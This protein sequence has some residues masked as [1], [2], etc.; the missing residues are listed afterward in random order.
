LGQ[1]AEALDSAGKAVELYESLR[2]L[3]DN[4]EL[5]MLWRETAS[6]AYELH[7]HDDVTRSAQESGLLDFARL[8][9]SRREADLLSSLDP[10]TLASVDFAATREAAASADV[11]RARLVHFATH[12]LMNTAHP[13][14]SGLVLSLVDEHGQPRD[15]FLRLHAIYDL[16][17]RADLVVL[18]ACQTAVG[19]EF[20]GE[21]MV[22]LTRGFFAAGAPRVIAS[23]WN[24]DDRATSELALLL[25]RLRAARR[26]ALSGVSAP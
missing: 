5:R 6:A 16:E 11:S 3:L 26:V 14:L 9:F 24:V 20:R 19:K 13:E 22:A 10:Q 18:S 2:T 23:H 4:P 15:G 17:L 8:R 1:S 25:G 12:S 21:G 7:P